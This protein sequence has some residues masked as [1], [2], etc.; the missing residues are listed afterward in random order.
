MKITN[1][2]LQ[3]YFNAGE[4]QT[5]T[6]GQALSYALTPYSTKEEYKADRVILNEYKD[7][8]FKVSDRFKGGDTVIVLK[9][10]TE[11]KDIKSTAA[12]EKLAKD[13]F[14]IV[15]LAKLERTDKK[16]VNEIKGKRFKIVT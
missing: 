1:E 3:D 14:I 16:L 13:D 6:E 7:W 5:Q 12:R 9:N 15:V 4:N 10:G 8:E 2:L 11:H